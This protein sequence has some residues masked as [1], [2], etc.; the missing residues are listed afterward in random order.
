MQVNLTI[1]YK[2]LLLL[3]IFILVP[4]SLQ[5][6]EYDRYTVQTG[7]FMAPELAQEQFDSIVLKLDKKELEHLRIE[8]IGKYYAVRLG[9]FKY[10]VTAEKYLGSAG[11]RLPGAIVL[12]ANIHDERIISS[13]T[14]SLL[15]SDTKDEE[16][17]LPDLSQPEIPEVPEQRLNEAP[18]VESVEVKS[19]ELTKKPQPVDEKSF[20]EKIRGRVYV[21]DYYSTDS[22]DFAFHILTGRLNLYKLEEKKPGFF[23][24]FDG[25]ARKK[26]FNRDSRSE[27]PEYKV[28]EFWGGYKFPG[29]QWKAIL[30]RQ[31]VHQLYNTYLDG[32]NV[33]YTFPSG[34][35]AGI[36]GGSAPDKNDNTFNTDFLSFG[37]YG[38]L[39]KPDHKINFGYEHLDYQGETDRE[40]FSARVYSR[41]NKKF[42]LNALSSVSQNQI[43][44]DFEVE[45][46]N[47]SLLYTH[48]R[49]LRFNVFYSYYRTIKFY[50]STKYYSEF[51]D[52][53]D[54]F[55][56]DNNS[57]TRSGVRVDYK[58]LKGL[59]VYGATSYQTRELDEEDAIRYT[60]GIRKYD[61]AG[62][63]VSA[64]YTYLD[65]YSS[66]SSEYNL[67]VYRN[68]LR[69]FD[70]SLYV[71]REEEKLDL[72]NSFTFG[73]ITYGATLYWPITKKIF[74]SS[75]VERI[76]QENYGNT[77]IYTQFGYKL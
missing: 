51:S 33:N 3:I 6:A 16:A 47:A 39:D 63:D 44:N 25:K 10:R 2:T 59:K 38:F 17:A 74:M 37:A 9:Q 11:S 26:F 13:Y 43:T 45:N 24:E 21:S 60:A 50:E 8:K 73:D 65:N 72:E 20:R 7:S 57:Q 66:R 56:L 71:S 40:Y 41:F 31:Y 67:E 5:A 46:A 1:K 64:R 28:H 53:D 14:E 27:V 4:I 19:V 77:S 75:F 30:G 76:D 23:F 34:F 61:L 52:V 49:K 15:P 29:L 62:F 48:S 69:K 18:P 36:F 68:I 58:I 42:R 35:G 32:L 70:V 55:L 22:S 12:R 54:T